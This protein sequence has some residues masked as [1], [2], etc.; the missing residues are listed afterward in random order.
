L[1]V[2]LQLTGTPD[3]VHPDLAARE[4]DFAARIWYPPRTDGELRAWAR[5]VQDVVARYGRRVAR[6]ELWNEPNIEEFWRP[7]PSPSEFAK[8]LRAGYVAAK[9]ADPDATIVSGGLSRND[10]GYLQR[11]YAAA[12]K[13]PGARRE[14]FF[15]DVLGLHPYSDDR[16]PSV[17]S[18]AFQFNGLYGTVDT[19]FSGMGRMHTAT[20][21]AE[22]RAKRIWIGEYGFSTTRSSLGRVHDAVRARYLKEAVSIARSAPGVDGLSWYAFLPGTADPHG[23]AIVSRRFRPSLTYKALEQATRPSK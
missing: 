4:P 9:A 22:G 16:A 23:W 7:A 19:N 5:F 13:L 3:W 20:A 21:K 10:L 12:D 14:R 8:L 18:P 6:Y 2:S 11:Y 15:F 17:N 1:R